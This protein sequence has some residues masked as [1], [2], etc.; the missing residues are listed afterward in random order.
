MAERVIKAREM[1]SGGG[2]RAAVLDLKDL[3]AEARQI[4]LDARGEAA[5]IIA[6]AKQQA[7]V[8]RRSAAEQGHAEGYAKGENLGY[9]DG[10]RRLRKRA[11]GRMEATSA[12]IIAL[13]KKVV[14]AMADAR[15]ELLHQARCQMLDFAIELARKIVGSVAVRDIEA[16]RANLAKVLESACTGG[17]I[18]V[19]VN[20]AQL[21]QLRA[22]CDELVEAIGIKDEVRLEPDEH[23]GPGG[24]K[25]L[26]RT[27]EI[28]ATIETQLGKVVDSLL[29]TSSA[30]GPSGRYRAETIPVP[31][32][33][34][35]T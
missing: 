25:L 7:E 5:R 27:G 14:Q 23:I 32:Q 12:E 16:A 1:A 24:V 9:S 30:P 6:Q 13:A 10:M 31:M 34:A 22:P 3:A 26:S 17:R 8:L 35:Q 29:G 2:P 18:T 15:E 19:R 21:P 28:D 11:D 33:S 20:P 4:V